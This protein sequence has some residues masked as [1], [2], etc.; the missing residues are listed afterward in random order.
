MLIDDVNISNR[1]WFLGIGLLL[2]AQLQIDT[3]DS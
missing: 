1:W 2:I 3:R